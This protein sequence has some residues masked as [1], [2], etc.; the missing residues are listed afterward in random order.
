MGN[1]TQTQLALA[2]PCYQLA[3]VLVLTLCLK[4]AACNIAG[5]ISGWEIFGTN[6]FISSFNTPVVPAG[7]AAI[8]FNK[9]DSQTC[10]SPEFRSFN[11][12]GQECSG[13]VYPHPINPTVF[14]GTAAAM[15]YV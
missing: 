15:Q 6:A 11:S 1:A 12:R 9:I 4:K 14:Q 3:Q 10:Q 2:C 13:N 8:E 5:V 7:L